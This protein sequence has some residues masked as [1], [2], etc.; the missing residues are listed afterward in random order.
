[1]HHGCS[2]EEQHLQT[3]NTSAFIPPIQAVIHAEVQLTDEQPR[4]QATLRTGSVEC[5]SEPKQQQNSFA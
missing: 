2:K 3:P 1:M 5:L 4:F